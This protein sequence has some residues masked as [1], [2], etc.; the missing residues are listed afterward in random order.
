MGCPDAVRA[1]LEEMAGV[2]KV[3]YIPGPGCFLR[4]TTTRPA[5]EVAAIFTAVFHAGKKMGT[6][7]LP[8]PRS[9]CPD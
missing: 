3:G 9:S 5:I 7:I 8:A 4:W 2:S 1:A 6:G